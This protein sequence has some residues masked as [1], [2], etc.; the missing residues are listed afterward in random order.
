MATSPELLAITC[1]KASQ[2]M[3]IDISFSL[4]LVGC[5]E[6]PCFCA[7]QQFEREGRGKMH[8]ALDQ[9]IAETINKL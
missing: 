5:Q 2:A 6:S 7:R 9:A 8:A 4:E 1:N 3:T